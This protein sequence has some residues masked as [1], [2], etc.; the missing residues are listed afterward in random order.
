MLLEMQQKEALQSGSGPEGR[1]G[2]GPGILTLPA[3][4]AFRMVVLLDTHLAFGRRWRLGQPAGQVGL[5]CQSP[6]TST[7]EQKKQLPSLT[8]GTS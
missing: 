4:K 3:S 5:A 2:P 1:R 6:R 8:P 7:Q